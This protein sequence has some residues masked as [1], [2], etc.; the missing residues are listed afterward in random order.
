MGKKFNN[1][2]SN[3]RRNTSSGS[4]PK[5][6]DL[7]SNPEFQK[8]ADWLSEVKF[9]HKLFGGLDPVDV[10]KKIEE[11]NTLYENALVAERVRYNLYL[12]QIM[13]NNQ[14]GASD[15]GEEPENV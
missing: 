5:G 7:Q 10:W 11:L 9:S 12:K 8:I 3:T 6:T 14:Q 1:S 4:I 15:E 2:T 13:K